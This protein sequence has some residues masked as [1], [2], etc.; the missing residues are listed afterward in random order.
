ML[1][2]EKFLFWFQ[3]DY[4]FFFLLK[5]FIRVFVHYKNMA[6]FNKRATTILPLI[7]EMKKRKDITGQGGTNEERMIIY[8]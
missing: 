4:N 2:C 7:S 6:V 5:K 3:N 8:F 1:L